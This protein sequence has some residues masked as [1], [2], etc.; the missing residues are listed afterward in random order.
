M[1]DPRTEIPLEDVDPRVRKGKYTLYKT[2][3][4]HPM[5]GYGN[6][7]IYNQPVWPYIA[8]TGGPLRKSA[9]SVSYTHLTLPTICSV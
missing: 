6:I 8:I 9:N 5:R 4:Y 3:G 7:E 2:G 1:I